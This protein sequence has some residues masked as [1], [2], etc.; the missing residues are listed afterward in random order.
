MANSSRSTGKRVNVYYIARVEVAG[1]ENELWCILELIIISHSP[2]DVIT[3]GIIGK[4]KLFTYF[5]QFLLVS[6]L[7]ET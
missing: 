3:D 7:I 4:V 6:I 1:I 5:S 2:S